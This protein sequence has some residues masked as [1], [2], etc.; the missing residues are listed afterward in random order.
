MQ[1]YERSASRLGFSVTELIH[2]IRTKSILLTGYLEY[3]LSSIRQQSSRLHL[4]I[5]SPSDPASRGS[6][7]SVLVIDPTA[8][9]EDTSAYSP[10]LVSFC[11]SLEAGGIIVDK[12]APD[13]VRLSPNAVYNTFEEVW[14]TLR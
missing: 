10:A 9:H 14:S 1:V 7:I 12:R 6:C 4:E 13:L 8:F 3:L 11:K 5:I 2:R